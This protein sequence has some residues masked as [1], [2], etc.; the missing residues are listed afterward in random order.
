MG[1]G[2]SIREGLFREGSCLIDE[3]VLSALIELFDLEELL[4]REER[5]ETIV[6]RAD[7]V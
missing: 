7:V 4:G 3:V 1:G 5:V 2:L 6:C